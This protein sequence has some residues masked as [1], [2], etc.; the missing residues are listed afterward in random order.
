MS[1]RRL[2]RQQQWR[3]KKIQDERTER[4]NKR[5]DAADKALSEGDLGPE[6]RGLL[7]SHFGTQVDVE[8]LEGERCGEIQRC[9][10][11]ANL[12]A[13]VTGDEVI[14]RPG[15]PTGVIVAN[16]PRRSIL[17][18][19]DNHGQIKPVASNIDLIVIV[20]CAE[21][22]P[23]ANLI[24]RYLVAAE[25]VG[26]S[27]LILLNKT[28]LLNDS[29]QA[30]IEDL[31]HIYPQ[32]NYPVVRASTKTQH[33]LEE[34]KSR[35]AKHTSV[36]VGQSGVG[37]SSLIN[38]LLP[39][40]DIKVGELSQAQ[41]AGKGKGKHT[42]T[43][44]RLFHFPG[45]GDLIDSPGIREFSLW[46]MDQQQLLDGFV[47]FRPYLGYCRFRDCKHDQ[48]PGCAILKALENGE[49]SERRMNSFRHIA[50]SVE[51]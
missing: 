26:I 5:G 41:G 20:I 23:H 17:H 48:E 39:G 49:I 14:W 38:V 50:S 13:L 25:N 35:L 27:P 16:K 21:P 9:H 2:S 6:Q 19:P 44:A 11:R 33:G 29:N 18:R 40:S 37:K 22:R 3:I 34:L 8:A 7:I 32:L 30:E 12:E 45:G 28:D 1:K 51:Q 36:F 42:T 4:A 24:D 47:E 46:H 43:T 15:N 10:I 31:L